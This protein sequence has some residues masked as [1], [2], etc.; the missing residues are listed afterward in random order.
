MSAESDYKRAAR[1]FL[2]AKDE[3]EEARTQLH[4]AM[5]AGRKAGM[6]YDALAKEVGL[7][8]QRV[9]AILRG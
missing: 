6:T 9:M 8:R 5:R 4:A 1:R 2:K 3:L 7:T